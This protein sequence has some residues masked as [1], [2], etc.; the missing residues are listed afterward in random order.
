MSAAERFAQELVDV[1]LQSHGID[2]SD[3]FE[4]IRTWADENMWNGNWDLTIEFD[5]PKYRDLR[6]IQED[7]YDQHM[8]DDENPDWDSM[9]GD[10]DCYY[11]FFSDVI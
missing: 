11:I 4:F 9:L 10:A 8:D 1:M 7:E 5:N 2:Y 6:L 3:Q